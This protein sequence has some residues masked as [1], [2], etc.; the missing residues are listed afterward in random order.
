MIVRPGDLLV[1]ER[2]RPAVGPTAQKTSADLARVQRAAVAAAARPFD[3][4]ARAGSRRRT[5]TTSPR[6][7]QTGLDVEPEVKSTR[8]E[9]AAH[10]YKE[11]ERC[12]N[13]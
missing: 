1:G 8:V 10:L 4:R 12:I 5:G 6:R 7:Q 2:V 13:M 3:P 11:R 9:V